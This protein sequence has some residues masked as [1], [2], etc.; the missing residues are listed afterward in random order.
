MPAVEREKI[1]PPK[2]THAVIN[3]W[4]LHPIGNPAQTKGCPDENQ[5][6]STRK[7][8]DA[9]AALAAKQESRSLERPETMDGRPADRYWELD[10]STSCPM[11][12]ARSS[13]THW[14]TAHFWRGYRSWRACVGRVHQSSGG[15]SAG[16]GFP[17]VCQLVRHDDWHLRASI[18]AWRV[19]W[20]N[21]NTTGIRAELIGRRRGNE[22]VQEGKFPDGT[23]IRW[24]F[25]EPI[26]F[27]FVGAES[28]LSPTAKG[29]VSS[30]VSGEANGLRQQQSPDFIGSPSQGVANHS[31][32]PTSATALT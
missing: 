10:L 15:Q 3:R 26:T 24:T 30:R 9:R 25:D 16:A 7:S 29:G 5:H 19:N 17:E 20:F 13:I 8:T 2:N 21:P 27:H 32:S 28:G 4:G 31:S 14:M 18:Q 23:P 22:I 11:M 12:T 1:L 6:R